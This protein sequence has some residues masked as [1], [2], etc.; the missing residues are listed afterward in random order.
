[1]RE[2][3]HLIQGEFIKMRRTKLFRIH[4]MIPVAG[5]AVFLLYY[6]FSLWSPPGKV[7][8]Y[9]ETMAS[10]YPFLAGLI[11]AMSVEL[12]EEGHMQTFLLSGR[13]KCSI[14]LGKWL[15]LLML[16]F[17]AAAV[18]VLGFAA[19][20]E[21]ILR[22]NPFSA[23]FYIRSLFAIWLGAAVLYAFH[24]FLSLRFGK[25]VSL[26]AGIAE[27]VLSAVMLTGLGEGCW[28]F[29]P[30]AWGGR[31]SS[32]LLVYEAGSLPQKITGELAVCAAAAVLIIAGIFLWFHYY[33][34]R[35]SEE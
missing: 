4:L 32:Y 5:A 28:P 18:A 3:W 25:S 27:S 29:F 23:G 20:Y 34:G 8:G 14:F 12:E 13:R 22:E 15:A 7:Q 17:T 10:V 1:M 24:L 16:S 11:C 2:L 9:L 26:A 30:C 19:G 6:S 35:R 33:E 21:F 31:W